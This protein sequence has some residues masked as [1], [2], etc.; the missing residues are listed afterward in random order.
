MAKNRPQHLG[1]IGS[2]SHLTQQSET[3]IYGLPDVKFSDTSNIVFAA[4]ISVGAIWNMPIT[5]FG[6]GSL[7]SSWMDPGGNSGTITVLFTPGG[8]TATIDITFPQNSKGIIRVDVDRNS[9][10]SALDNRGKGPPDP[11]GFIVN[12][13]TTTGVTPTDPNITPAILKLNKPLVSTWKNST[14]RQYYTWDKPVSGFASSDISISVAG[15]GTA[16]AGDLTKD[17][18]DNKVY[19]QDITLSGSGTYQISVNSNVARGGGAKQDNSPPAQVSTSWAFDTSTSS[20]TFSISDVTVLCSETYQIASN[21]ELETPSEGGLFLGVSDMKVHGSKL[22]FVSQ[23]Q[24]KRN[25]RDEKSTYEAS[26]G[27]LVS[28]PTDSGN[29]TIHKRYQFFRKAAR[30]LVVHDSLLHFFEGSAYIY[31]GSA[32]PNFTLQNVGEGL[33]FIQR[34]NTY[35]NIEQVGLNWRS[36]FPTGTQDQYNGVHGGTFCPMLSHDNELNMISRKFDFFDV[37]G[38]L[39]IVYGENI[40]DRISLLETNGKTGFEVLEGLAGLNNSIIGFRGGQ[41]RFEPRNP[42]QAFLTSDLTDSAISLS[43]KEINR[44]HTWASTGIVMISD[45]ILTYSGAT[46]TTLTGLKRGQHGTTANSHST[47]DPVVLIDEVIN[48]NDLARPINEMDIETDSTII[49]NSII[50]KYA[51]DQVPRLNELGFT[52]KDSD[53]ISSYGERK[54][55][56]DL[57]LDYHQQHLAIR[58]AKD[59][60]NRY[61]DL[62]YQIRLSLKHNSNINLGDIVYLSEPILSNINILCQV[63]AVSYNKDSEET[64]ITV[65]SIN[66]IPRDS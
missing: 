31:D 19:Y 61:K 52:T 65:L 33:G 46:S 50:T 39:W 37:N 56:L 5:G 16:T 24:R 43:Y 20:T 47:D 17:S 15:T 58:V 21:S 64:D 42:T 38:E 1:T 14:W 55:T 35:G 60:L 13:D 36:G 63:M 4:K 22:Y 28:V 32:Q 29:C 26:A 8:T 54:F 59:Y 12:Y 9:V 62:Q 41:F 34:I 18:D 3:S 51:K 48:A 44:V 6:I 66:P 7:S 2:G 40:N 27:A 53:S 10:T 30:S 57:P 49:R 25:G 45:E 23:I 11:R